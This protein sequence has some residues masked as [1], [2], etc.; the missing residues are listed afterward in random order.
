M[1]LEPMKRMEIVVDTFQLKTV[2]GLLHQAGVSGYTV[3]SNASGYGDRGTQ[4]ADEVSGASTNSYILMAVPIDKLAQIMAAIK[5]VL[6][7]YGGICLVSDCQ[8][9]EH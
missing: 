5:P 7:T 2:T 4:R 1:K 9:L 3:L 8:W 6:D